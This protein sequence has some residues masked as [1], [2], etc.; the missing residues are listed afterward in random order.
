M[1]AQSERTVA[2]VYTISASRGLAKRLAQGSC[3][4]VRVAAT[5]YKWVEEAGGGRSAR[6]EV[7]V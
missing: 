1:K 2:L 7:R 3:S 4:D 6:M 5:R